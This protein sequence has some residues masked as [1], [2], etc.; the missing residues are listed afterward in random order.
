MAQHGLFEGGGARI[1]GDMAAEHLSACI[2]AM[3]EADR[4][5]A[6]I[7]SLSFCDEVIVVD[8][9][10]SDATREVAV[11]LGAR[12]IERDWEGFTKQKQFAVE[13]ATHDWVLCLDADERVS[14]EL[15]VELRALKESGFAGPGYTMPRLTQWEGMWIRRGTWYPDRQLRV[16]D[17][18]RGSWQ[19]GAVHE[20]VV[21]DGPTAELTG[22][23]LHESYRDL[24][25]HLGTIGKY[26]KLGAENLAAKGRRASIT[27]LWVRPLVRFLRFYVLGRGFLL[28]W[29]GLSLA[30]L[31]AHYVHL[32]YLR[33]MIDQERE[34]PR[35]G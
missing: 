21:L 35:N 6:C 2:I 25:E 8:S 34:G 11:S 4:I 12:V 5:G 10:S 1:P 14:P 30:L 20:K 3:D 24:D 29:R 7:E 23:L 26:T 27:D 19:G 31:G 28:G 18:R 13:A 33:R 15:E 16:F 22:D 17:R 9:H 32:K